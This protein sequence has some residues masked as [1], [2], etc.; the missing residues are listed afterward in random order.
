MSKSRGNKSVED[1]CH[2][3]L[4]HHL[5]S[6]AAGNRVAQLLQQLVQSFVGYLVRDIQRKPRDAAVVLVQVLD[7]GLVHGAVQP[8]AI[9]A[10]ACLFIVDALG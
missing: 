3:S 4:E 2:L 10:W 9:W 1:T 5:R 7:K 6:V 8:A